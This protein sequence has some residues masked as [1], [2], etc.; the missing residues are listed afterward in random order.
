MGELDGRIL[1][2]LNSSLMYCSTDF[3]CGIINNKPGYAEWVLNE[4][5]TKSDAR[6]ILQLKAQKMDQLLTLK[7]KRIED[8]TNRLR[9]HGI[10]S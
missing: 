7:D 1:P 8:L 2:A 10:P 9:Q 5:R 6:Q 4:L 3:S